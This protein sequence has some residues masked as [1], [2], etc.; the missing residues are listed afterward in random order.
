MNKIYGGRGKNT[1]VKEK[2]NAKEKTEK[3]KRDFTNELEQPKFC[4]TVTLTDSSQ[5]NPKIK[6]TKQKTIEWADTLFLLCSCIPAI[7]VPVEMNSETTDRTV[8]VCRLI[9]VHISEKI[10]LHCQYNLINSFF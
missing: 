8:S 10:S 7:T 3:Q 9:S 1:T 6:Q 4:T 2:A 5:E